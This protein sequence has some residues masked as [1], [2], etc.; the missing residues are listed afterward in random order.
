VRGFFEAGGFNRHAVNAGN[1]R[2][3]HIIA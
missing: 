3:E 2:G 1:E